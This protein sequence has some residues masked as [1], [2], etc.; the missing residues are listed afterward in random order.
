MRWKWIIIGLLMIAGN[1][2]TAQTVP[3]EAKPK[4]SR[5]DTTLKVVTVVAQRP[6]IKQ[7]DDKTIID[8]EQL[9]GSSS[10]AYEV[11]EKAPGIV[12][13]Q[14]G[15]IYLTSSSPATI[16][17]NG[18]QMRMS[19][20]DLTALLKSLPSGS[21]SK[22]EILRTPSA[23]FDASNS[24]GI[25]NVVLKKGIHLGTV[26][27]INFRYDQGVYGT[28][29]AGFSLNH[30]AGKINTFVSYQF[31]HRNYYEEINSHRILGTDTTLNQ[32]TYTTYSPITQYIG[33]GVEMELN[34]KLDLAYDLRLTITSNNSHAGSSNGLSN[35]NDQTEFSRTSSVISNEGNTLFVSN[36]LTAKYSIDS[37]GSNWTTEF[38]Y[39]YTN[40]RNTQIY[41]TDYL[42]PP[43]PFV[44][45]DGITHNPAG[46]ADIL[47]DLN[48]H[49]P[50]AF[51]LETGIKLSYADN[52]NDANYNKQSG[53]NPPEPDPYQ[54]NR[55]DYRQ[56]IEAA[57]LQLTKTYHHFT[58][59]SGLRL[60]HTDMEG[61]QLIPSDST[62]SIN[63]NDLFPYLFIKKPLFKIFGYPLTGNIVLR[64][65]ITRPT[66][67]GLNPSPKFVDPFTF[68][69][70]N[71][72]LRPQFTS[73]YEVNV[74]YNDF[75]VFAIGVNNTKDVI[76]SVVYQ[77]DVTKIS[78]RTYDN[79]GSYK[80]IYGRLFGGLP[81]GH[82]YFMYAGVQ[83]NYIQYHGQ[84][85]NG[86]LD[87]SR[88]SWTFFTGHDLKVAP[89]V[90]LNLN[91]W[92]YVNGFRNFYALKTM[93]QI[94]MSVT[95]TLL[96]NKINI[97]L[98]GNDILKTN[99]AVF[100][101]KQNNILSNGERIQDSRRFGISIRYNFGLAHHEEKKPVFE[102]P[103]VNTDANQ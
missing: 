9:A 29:S 98:F 45:G 68:N 73:N 58:F 40:T 48:I 78:Y 35:M 99:K 55:F 77:N 2:V 22:I 20:E 86:P 101:L 90:K 70:G 28:A 38:D 13:D 87:Y 84:Y 1:I 88:G 32:H 27:S 59:K 57:Y 102:P 69:I 54:T 16:Y 81:A 14:D 53:N 64:R 72:H 41:I 75:P 60:E 52:K 43:A 34:K 51:I 92:L 24:G 56:N 93:G 62:F 26:G 31:T 6:L 12:L 85:Q 50:H 71:P 15:N 66:Y 46:A 39:T 30:S 33:G 10:N 67:E 96:S 25:V 83:Y 100:L 7:E 37:A 61:Q 76:S 95:K 3:L 23:K 8:A 103:P 4:N 21:I 65:S 18:R 17:I 5:F 47:S 19:T 91:A 63:R 82:K 94:N 49:L 42:L 80:E 44:S 97:V 74:T 89:T 36:S 79:L 11:L